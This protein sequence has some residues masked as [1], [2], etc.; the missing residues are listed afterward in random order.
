M[1]WGLRRSLRTKIAFARPNHAFGRA[2][3]Q[4]AR[5]H[6]A[7]LIERARYAVVQQTHGAGGK[8]SF[9]RQAC[10]ALFQ[11]P[12]AGKSSARGSLHI[13]KTGIAQAVRHSGPQAI[14]QQTRGALGCIRA[15][16]REQHTV[17]AL[18]LR[19]PGPE[20]PLA[21]FR[22]P[23]CPQGRKRA[24]QAALRLAP[25]ARRPPTAV[26]ERPACSPEGR[27]R[28]TGPAARPDQTQKA[29]AHPHA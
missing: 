17:H 25:A 7:V 14:F 20:R 18:F 9:A 16:G 29:P 4:F 13:E 28:S 23:V 21:V 19:G 1:H 27:S 22:H 26:G 3:Q 12:V 6:V 10:E 2:A 24:A 5:Q 11:R 8:A 15:L